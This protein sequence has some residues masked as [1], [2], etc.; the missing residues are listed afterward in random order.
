MRTRTPPKKTSGRD[1]GMSSLTK[2]Q[3]NL[4]NKR[5]INEEFNPRQYVTAELSEEDVMQ[6]K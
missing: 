1:L 2:G 6:I 5:R 4:S 3:L